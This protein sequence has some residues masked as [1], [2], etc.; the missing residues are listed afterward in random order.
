MNLETILVVAGVLFALVLGILIGLHD[1]SRSASSAAT[2]TTSPPVRPPASWSKP[3]GLLLV[4]TVVTML[5]MMTDSLG[6]A[7]ASLKTNPFMW[8]AG[9]T[10]VGF[11]V[12]G[13]CGKSGDRGTAALWTIFIIA[14]GVVIYNVIVSYNIIGNMMYGDRADEVR[15]VKQERNAQ[16]A[17]NPPPPASSAR[18]PEPVVTRGEAEWKNRQPDGTIPPNVWS[19][20]ILVEAHCIIS[21][22]LDDDHK[23]EWRDRRRGEVHPFVPYSRV[24]DVQSARFSVA[25][26]GEISYPYKITCTNQ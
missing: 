24:M 4:V 13:A 14:V 15:I 21:M 6:P 8:I 12:L 16:A 23:G 7:L 25:V 9:L 26:V 10:V 18:T 11:A 5:V 17:L 2:S 19:E 20:W 1:S 3:T 22:W